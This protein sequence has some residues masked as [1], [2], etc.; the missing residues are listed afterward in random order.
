MK[1]CSYCKN[2]I[3]LG[4]KKVGKRL[5]CGE[6]CRHAAVDV[7]GLDAIP[8]DLVNDLASSIH[9]GSC[10]KCGG[11]GPVDI[12]ESYRVASAFLFSF[13][14]TKTEVCCRKCSF[15][16]SFWDFIYTFTLG[17]W[18]FPIGVI[19]T[20]ILLLRNMIGM[21]QLPKED[22][23]SNALHEKACFDLAN[24]RLEKHGAAHA[25]AATVS[26]VRSP[27]RGDKLEL[28]T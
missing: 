4:G 17:W 11:D 19:L 23:Y 16:N 10:P 21:L 27:Q 13:F 7:L 9:K 6:N 25:S 14:N 15:K 24:A 8:E 20:P 28:S 3:V 2:T 12:H 26:E 1:A 22:E 5:Y 18:G